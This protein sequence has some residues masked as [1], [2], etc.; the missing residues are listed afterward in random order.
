MDSQMKCMVGRSEK[1]HCHPPAPFRQELLDLIYHEG[2][3]YFP[4]VTSLLILGQ[5]MLLAV[6]GYLRAECRSLQNGSQVIRCTE[7]GGHR[8]MVPTPWPRFATCR[9]QQR[10]I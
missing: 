3:D 9:I 8:C 7:Y 6:V 10:C 2:K 4:C 1:A 5:P